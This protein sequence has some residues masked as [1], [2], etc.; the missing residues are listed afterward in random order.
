MPILDPGQTVLYLE[1]LRELIA[2]GEG[3]KVLL[4]Q[5]RQLAEVIYKKL[6][7]DS[8]ISFNGLFARMQYVHERLNVPHGLDT[9]VQ[10]LRILCNKAAHDEDADTSESAWLSGV[11]AVR[12]LLYWLDPVT[13]DQELDSYLEQHG[14]EPFVQLTAIPRQDFTCVASSWS[15]AKKEGAHCGIT[16][17]ATMDDGS[18]CTLIL[19]DLE[20]EGKRWSR[21]DKVLWQHCTLNC[22]NL[23]PVSGREGCFQSNPSTLVVLE[24]DF[25]IEASALAEC[26][27]NDGSRPEYF[28]INKMSREASKEK[29][30]QGN[31]V[32]T[33]LDELIPAPERDYGDL[34]RES[35]ARQPISMVA[36]G[37][38]TALRIYNNIRENHL[39]AVREFTASVS[40]QQV[41]LEPSFVSPRFGL[42]GRLDILYEK[43]G[44]R[45]IVEL[46]S[47]TAPHFD[48][49]KNNQ[50]QVTAYNLLIR[51]CGELPQG[52]SS[53]LYSVAGENGLRHVANSQ[54]QEQELLMCRNRVVGIMH[55]LAVD[56]RPF[57]NW[58]LECGAGS[59]VPYM[60]DK[61]REV[62]STLRSLPG[63]EYEWFLEQFRLL[64]R[65]IWF[66]K[67]GGLG[68]D[69]IYGHNALWQESA[70]AKIDRYR[71]LDSLALEKVEFNLV[72][73]SISDSGQITDFRAGDAVVL[74]RRNLPVDRQE[75][76]RGQIKAISEK[77][78]VVKIRGGLR[79]VPPK[80]M[81]EL[82]ALEH[83]ILESSLYSSISSIM[84][85]LQAPSRKRRL[86]LG[87][88]PPISDPVEEQ[89]AKGLDRVVDTL[90]ATRDYHIIQGP[91]GT[92]KTSGLLTN[93]IKKAYGQSGR[94]ILILS[95]T[96]RAVD[97]ICLNLRKLSIPFIRTGQSDEIGQ[98]LMDTLISGKKFDEISAIL[99]ANRIWVATVQSCNAWLEDLLKIIRIDEVVIDEASQ[100]MENNILGIIARIDKAI[101]IGDQ[102]Q[103][104]P[105]TMQT[106][107]GFSFQA[108]ELAGLCYGSYNQSLME[109]LYRVC[110][111]KGWS[112][113]TTMLHKHYRMHE[114][115]ATLIQKY[116]Q[117]KLEAV[118]PRQKE[119]LGINAPDLLSTRLAWIE[120]PPSRYAY[121]DPL[122]VQCI[123][124][125]L[126]MLVDSGIA[127]DPAR[128]VGIVA[129][130]RAMIHAVRQALPDSLKGITIDTVER[131]QGSE[132][133]IIIM[134]LPLRD[135]S[136]L[137]NI[138]ALS[139][140]GGVDRKLNVSVSRAQERLIVLGCSAI[141]RKSAH[142][143]LLLDKIAASGRM[144][145]YEDII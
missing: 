10:K 24:P 95:F 115:L 117:D 113:A 65:E 83:D 118:L 21:L 142:Y 60:Q 44:K 93:Y 76:L 133:E 72:T 8:R 67:T 15:L 100:I 79:Q 36:L 134:T 41:Q 121:Y 13:R 139:A 110:Q 125:I 140:D 106:D 136:A 98:E 116:Y 3:Y 92:G 51:N 22:F 80:Y 132:R 47:G 35:L 63:Y 50:M 75:I 91:P 143:N 43:D 42:Q 105:I 120:F 96:N 2:S 20:D 57:F 34:F 127:G 70:R 66:E 124:K 137:R 107:Q 29:P 112:H 144:F 28:I 69:S 130:F 18:G 81:S 46:K 16:I 12:D 74:Y 25:L 122:Q 138:E 11:L 90:S 38:E 61:V 109:R 26:F 7:E 9:Q 59:G 97:E 126:K 49:W 101:L 4:I 108:K 123:T 56:P 94:N 58:L 62:V 88:E 40:N 30:V 145:N 78:L 37:K 32:N 14:A 5:L 119:P 64:I 55:G 87:I 114:Q 31:M 45:H 54:K 1:R 68:R 17:N 71:L 33:I 82:W 129:P 128:D 89:N 48:V 84:A 52:F 135:G 23:T 99:K 73:Y 111:Q 86:F 39:P 131:F 102:N 19:N 53:I 6:S 141:C 85:F 104:P 77:K 27:N 103:L